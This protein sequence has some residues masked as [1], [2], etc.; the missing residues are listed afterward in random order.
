[1]S[2]TEEES[3]ELQ[4]ERYLQCVSA[5][6]Y[7]RGDKPPRASTVGD[8]ISVL[9]RLPPD[10]K[11]KAGSSDCVEAVVVSIRDSRRHLRLEEPK[12]ERD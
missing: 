8:L 7:I 11:I 1:M 2:L 4:C 12:H 10:L 6:F 3:E 9:Q 5:E